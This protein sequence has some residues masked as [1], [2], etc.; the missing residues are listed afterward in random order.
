[1]ARSYFLGK[2][3]A[4]FPEEEIV[5][6]TD[7]TPLLA[8]TLV[9]SS[10]RPRYVTR[11]LSSICDSVTERLVQLAIE[12]LGEPPADFSFIA[13][14][15]QGR[16]EQ[17]LITDQDNGII[18][19]PH[20]DSDSQI[21]LEYFLRLGKMVNDGMAQAGYLPCRG[22]VMSGQPRWCRPLTEWKS[23]FNEWIQ[24]SEPQEIIDFSIFFDFRTIYGDAE[25]A[26]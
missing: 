11:T 18:F 25:L 23:G 3:P 17:T 16:Q 6:H 19:V 20:P 21:T 7:R 24:K 1:M 5:R 13:M 8:K 10:T 2:L 4:R 12:E 22:G 26:Q 14:G 9:E 15:S